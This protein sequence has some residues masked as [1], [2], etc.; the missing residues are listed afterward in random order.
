MMTKMLDWIFKTLYP[1][2]LLSC[3][4]E[5]KKESRI[6]YKGWKF[7]EGGGGLWVST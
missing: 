4:K 7:G 1:K 2:I 5:K 6:I 3:E